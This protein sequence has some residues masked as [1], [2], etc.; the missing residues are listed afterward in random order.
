MIS[1]SEEE[2][3]KAEADYYDALQ[4]ARI[5]ERANS[6]PQD[7]VRDW[8]DAQAIV[9]DAAIDGAWLHHPAES[10]AELQRRVEKFIQRRKDHR[11]YHRQIEAY[12]QGE[13]DKLQERVGFLQRQLD[14]QV[15]NHHEL[16]NAMHEVLQ[17]LGMEEPEPDEEDI[18]F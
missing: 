10:G 9:H 6:R 13:I 5:A 14:Q 12:Y 11:E 7:D 2:R 18:P 4:Q 15:L 17:K 1:R 16:C 3:L 8:Q